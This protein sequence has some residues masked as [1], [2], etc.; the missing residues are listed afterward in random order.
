MQIELAL[1]RYVQQLQAD[2]R[3][4]HTIG[5]YKRHVGL[6]GRW[7]TAHAHGADVEEIDHEDVARFLGSQAARSRPDGRTKRATSTNAL[8]TSLRTFFGFVHAAGYAKVNAAR[9]VR[10]AMCG[11]PP[12]RALSDAEQE[13]LLD[14]LARGKGELAQRDHALFHLMLATGIRLGSALALESRDVDLERGEIYLRC[15]KGDRPEVVYLGR[16]IRDHLRQYMERRDDGPLFLGHGRRALCARH[17]Q[18]RL[19]LWLARASVAQRASPHA[20]RHSFATTLYRRTGDVYLV[21]EA[22]KHRSIASTLVYAQANE[23]RLREAL[24]R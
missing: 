5:Q 8:R 18:R 2:G 21:K 24:A 20:L 12:P 22:L 19:A 16:A 6:F 7:L 13:R 3:S 23:G 9:L 11:T 14:A 4:P 17:V 10:R 15:T 1:D